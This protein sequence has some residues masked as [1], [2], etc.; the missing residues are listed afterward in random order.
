MQVLVENPERIAEALAF[1]SEDLGLEGAALRT[2]VV[3]FP[4]VLSYGVQ[5]RRGGGRR[6]PVRTLV[7]RFPHVL[8]YGVQVRGQHA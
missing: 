4:H 7:V 2:L 8:S 1:L 3:R 5:V 6:A